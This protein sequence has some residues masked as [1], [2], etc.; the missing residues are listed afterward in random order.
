MVQSVETREG[1]AFVPRSYELFIKQ[2]KIPQSIAKGFLS[3]LAALCKHM[4]YK[5][6]LSWHFWYICTT[7]S[8]VLE[9]EI[10]NI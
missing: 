1:H 6:Y 9:Y 7:A 8:N 10:R 2:N 4:V 5:L 3:T